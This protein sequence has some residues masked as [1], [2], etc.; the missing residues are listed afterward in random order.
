[1][2]YP[3]KRE[4]WHGNRFSELSFFWDKETVLPYCIWSFIVFVQCEIFIGVG[5]TLPVQYTWVQ[6]NAFS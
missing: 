6:R 2:G 1:M 5:V 4:L 3:W